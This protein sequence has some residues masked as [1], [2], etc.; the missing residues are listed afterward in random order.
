MVLFI[1][2]SFAKEMLHYI[3]QIIDKSLKQKS[4]IELYI[5]S[6]IKIINHIYYG[7]VSIGQPYVVAENFRPVS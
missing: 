7:F 5:Y 3:F 6:L 1:N 4:V 2:G